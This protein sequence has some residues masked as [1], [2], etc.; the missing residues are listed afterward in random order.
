MTIVQITSTNPRLG[1][2]IKKNPNSLPQLKQ[3]KSGVAFGY[4]THNRNDNLT[5]P[6]ETI[7]EQEYNVYFQDQMNAV[8]Y[9]ESENEEDCMDYTNK[10]RFMSPLC[11]LDILNSFFSANLKSADN[12]CDPDND[13]LSIESTTYEYRVFVNLIWMR[14]VA[15]RFF[16]LA[17]D[18]FI[19]TTD[20]TASCGMRSNNIYYIE[21][22]SKSLHFV[23]NILQ[24][25]IVLVILK[26]KI[27]PQINLESISS[28]LKVSMPVIGVSIPYLLAYMLL[29]RVDIKTFNA[30]TPHLSQKNTTFFH[31]ALNNRRFIFVHEMLSK[32][33]HKIDNIIDIGSGEGKYMDLLKVI[34]NIDP[35]N[36]TYHCIDIDDNAIIQLKKKASKFVNYNI[37]IIQ[38]KGDACLAPHLNQSLEQLSSDQFNMVIMIEVIEHMENVD[39]ASTLLKNVIKYLPFNKLI[40]TTPNREF[41]VH[42]GLEKFR[43]DD[44]KF[45][46][47]GSEFLTFITE[48]CEVNN[49]AFTIYGIGDIVDG[50]TPTQCAVINKTK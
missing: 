4:Y 23:L 28:K 8:S 32:Q 36:I 41:N 18:N 27:W 21:I 13:N 49:C 17:L 12:I 5:D 14:P 19:K 20:I 16:S 37:N 2:L 35:K 45:E 38:S 39:D 26:N 31:G 7:L 30:I 44:H 42:Y 9:K 24:T 43:H 25:L 29:S 50:I 3:I 6:K 10:L 40:V 15:Y 1:Y 47:T 48:C 11:V 34:K 46:F 22:S 33:K